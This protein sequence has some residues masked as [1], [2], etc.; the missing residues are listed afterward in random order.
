MN[1]CDFIREV[2]NLR[3]KA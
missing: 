1:E 2:E 3:W